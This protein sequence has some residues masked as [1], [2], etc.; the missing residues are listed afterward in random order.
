MAARPIIIDCD[1]GQ[2][3]AVMLLL[4]LASP[5]ELDVRGITTVAGNVP[6]DLTQRNAR[7]M[8]DLAGRTELAVYAG[9]AR[10]MVRALITAEAVHG[11]TGIDGIELF[12]P[13]TPLQARHGVDFLVEALMA[14]PAPITLVPAGPLTNIAMALVK[15]PRIAA[16]IAEIVLMGGAWR[17]GGN[18]SPAA[19]FNI[20][21]D[22]HAAHVVFTCGRPIVV[23]SL[24][25][26]HQALTT[27]DRLASIGAIDSR[28]GRSVH[29]M[30]E[31]YDRHDIE[32]YGMPGGPLH[33]PCT[34]AYLLRPDLFAGKDVHVAVDTTSEAS[35]GATLVD[36]WGVTGNAP[37]ANWMH[38]I[39]ADG[40]YQLLTDRLARL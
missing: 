2:D 8:C 33:D 27:P 30:L 28:V 16:N 38:T 12:N 9:C 25:V 32:K 35:M 4:A 7:I 34:I 10:P 5:A 22:P 26:T 36:Y 23:M 1:P 29:A 40:F 37:N 39:D 18:T 20:L 15:E 21:V 19:E 24:D 3:D 13:V 14:A 31:F 17:E 11:Q 6:L